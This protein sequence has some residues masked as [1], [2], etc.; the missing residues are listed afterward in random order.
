MLRMDLPAFFFAVN[1]FPVN[2]LNIFRSFTARKDTLI[3]SRHD[4]HF[5][6]LRL[7]VADRTN[8]KPAS[9]RHTWQTG[10]TVI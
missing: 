5:H 10:L 8:L 7:P 1:I 3:R 2:H 9:R 6:N 4:L